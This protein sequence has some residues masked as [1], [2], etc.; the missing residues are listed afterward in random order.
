MKQYGFSNRITALEPEG[1][2]KYNG[3]VLQ[4]T[5]RY[6]RNFSYLAAYTWSHLTDDATA[7]INSTALT[8]RRPQSFGNLSS[9]WANS[10]LDRRQR[11]TITPIF[12]F[13]PFSR[14]GW[15]LKNLAGNWNFAFSYTYESPEYGTAQSN[16]DS[17]LN[18]DSATDRAIV[19]PNGVAG[20]G[21]GVQGYDRNG[22]PVGSTSTAIVAYVA[23]NPNARYIVAGLGAFANSGRN[24]LPFAPIDNVDGSVRKVF[25]LTEQRRFE[26]GAQF[27]NLLNHP[28]FVPGNLNDIAP[29]S[30][31][32]R[33]FLIPG[34]AA[35]GQY[36][37]FFPSNSRYVQILARFAF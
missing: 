27:Y 3:L 36:Q 30:S 5:K 24:T 10:L 22:N 9:E 11:L 26:I 37:Q 16:V 31:L 12:D 17:N 7:D 14:R 35:F 20:T 32:N 33:N 1:N 21:S 23:N 29:S 18:G 4:V 28:K 13:K 34:N 8:P 2:S 19:N 15:A 6:S 25:N